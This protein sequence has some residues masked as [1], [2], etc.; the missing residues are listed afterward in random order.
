MSGTGTETGVG[1]KTGT[2]VGTETETDWTT[3]S[4]TD[5]SSMGGGILASAAETGGAVTFPALKQHPISFCFLQCS[6][7]LYSHE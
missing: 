4:L 2:G 1:T 3:T 6:L 7:S 5:S